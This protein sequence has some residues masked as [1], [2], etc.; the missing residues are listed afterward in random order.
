MKRI[1]S[2]AILPEVDFSLGLP[3]KD[4]LKQLIECLALDL[5]KFKIFQ[6]G[7]KIPTPHRVSQ[8]NTNYY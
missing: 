4:V 6:E 5:K 7:W 3:S 2:V 1:L 8:S